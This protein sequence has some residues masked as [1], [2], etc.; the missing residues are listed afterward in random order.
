M[1]L[2][3]LLG[4]LLVLSAD[5]SRLRGPFAPSA[6]LNSSTPVDSGAEDAGNRLA[7][8]S[9]NT[10]RVSLVASLEGLPTNLSSI[11]DNTTA[12]FP[13]HDKSDEVD[14]QVI[15]SS[16]LLSENTSSTG[17]TLRSATLMGMSL[18]RKQDVPPSD[19]VLVLFHQTSPWSGHLIL[20]SGFRPGRYG[21]CGGGIYFATSPEATDHKAIGSDSQ[22]GYI[23]GAKVDLGKIKYMNS[24]CD[25]SMTGE[26]L[27]WWGYDSIHF[28]PG[29]GVEY[30]VYSKDRIVS[31]W[32]H[33]A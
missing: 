32:H 12:T 3:I 14:L 15:G 22:K 20:R 4:R 27:Q 9:S 18:R 23:I 29:D 19:A 31:M 5:E 24:T 2:L 28:N 17:T 7:A 13:M 25:K 16:G 6:P 30:V 11:Q 21:W 33:E 26:K 1:V 8:E 10:F